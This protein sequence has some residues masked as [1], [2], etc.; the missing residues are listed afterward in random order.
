MFSVNRAK[1]GQ[2]TNSSNG[3]SNKSTDIGFKVE[4]YIN[5][6][7]N[8]QNPRWQTQFLD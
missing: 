6:N 7:K 1:S 4:K 3:T 8:D 5:F 2:P